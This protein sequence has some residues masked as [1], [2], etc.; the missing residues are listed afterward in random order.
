VAQRH[1]VI[2]EDDL[3]GG[4]ADETIQL[5]F[6][7][8]NYEIDLNKS[9]AEKLRSAMHLYLAR[10]RCTMAAGSTNRTRSVARDY[11]PKAVRTWAKSKQI[12]VPTRG[13]IPADVLVQFRAA[14]Q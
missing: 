3:D 14:E 8:K 7:G 9:N 10:A 4:P 12:D 6:E 2:L 1:E 13:R 5:M 11:D